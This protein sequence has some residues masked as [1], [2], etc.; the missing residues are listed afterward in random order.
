MNYLKVKLVS[1]CFFMAITF[2]SAKPVETVEIVYQ[3]LIESI[4]NRITAPTLEIIP[5]SEAESQA[6]YYPAYNVIV[7]SEALLIFARKYEE[8][9]AIVLAL[10]LG[11]ELAHHYGKHALRSS[12][13]TNSIDTAR[14]N[15]EAEADYFAIFFAYLA[16]YPTEVIEADF[17]K[18][19]YTTFGIEEVANSHYPALEKRIHI[20]QE[21]RQHINQLAKVFQAGN[22]LLLIDEYT[23]A[24]KCFEFIA[25][26][27]NSPEVL[28]NTGVAYLQAA[29][30]LFTEKELPFLLPTELE[31][32]SNL[33][34]R[35]NLRDGQ[36][37]E[38]E[39]IQKRNV[40]LELATANF[41]DALVLK[42]DY[43][44]A[45]INLTNVLL[46]K[47]IDSKN[48]D[49]IDFQLQQ[50]IDLLTFYAQEKASPIFHAKVAL[51]K[52]LNHFLSQQTDQ[53]L[54]A[55][56]EGCQNNK[57]GL[58]CWNLQKWQNTKDLSTKINKQDGCAT[59]EAIANKVLVL[60]ATRYKLDEAF[61]TQSPITLNG[62]THQLMIYHLAEET[63]STWRIEWMDNQLEDP[64]FKKIYFLKTKDAYHKKNCW[65]IGLG[66]KSE[67]IQKKY[68]QPFQ[69]KNTN[70]QQYLRYKN[71]SVLFGIKDNSVTQMITYYID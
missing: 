68:G 67:V 40:Y 33:S 35:G 7:V 26:Q 12:F 4:G 36:L 24:A 65:A 66:T 25:N 38:E 27:F 47:K 37:S 64:I 60:P 62:Y 69:I 71:G 34:L 58:A 15:L 31:E 9:E 52:G 6:Q 17:L 23:A 55:F 29:I 5:A 21:A 13:A 11:H 28:N 22:Q 42:S 51:L 3:D 30:T 44:T 57:N 46:L 1:C 18:D 63:Y 53:M 10:I 43:T 39:R 8:K 2:L 41:R 45:Q 32:G 49:F 61:S 20:Y 19:F 56:E 14:A 48:S 16:G 54:T 59:G 70:Q 50:Q